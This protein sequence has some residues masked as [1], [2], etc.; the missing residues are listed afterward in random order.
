MRFL[1]EY[2]NAVLSHADRL[3]IVASGT[4]PL[5]EVGWGLVLVDGFTAARWRAS[6][7]DRTTLR[8]E[9]FRALTKIERADVEEE[10]VRLA[11]FLTDGAGSAVQIT[12]SGAPPR[13]S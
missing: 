3:R 8:V 12:R 10:A 6:E 11:Y 13:R 4:K 7:N 5:T 9:P 1:P 2:D